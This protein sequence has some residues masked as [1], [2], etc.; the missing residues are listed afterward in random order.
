MVHPTR[1]EPRAARR[2]AFRVDTR[3]LRSLVDTEGPFLTVA[4]P[5]PSRFDDAAHRFEINWRNARSHVGTEWPEQAL[6]RLDGIVADAGHGAGAALF[7]VDSSDGHTLVEFLDEPVREVVASVDPLPRLAPLIESRQRTIAHV[8][9]ETDRAGADLTAFDG[10]EVVTTASIEGETLHIH[11][12]HPGGW[13][14]RRFQQRA[15]NT[16]EHNARTTAEAVAAL[17]SRVDAELIAVAGEVRAR[18]LVL[19]ELPGV[20]NVATVDLQSGSATGIADEVVRR[21]SD[22]VARRVTDLAERVRQGLADGTACNG[23]DATLR[24]L[25]D[26]RV[27][28]L[29]VHDDIDV[30]EPRATHGEIAGIQESRV[31][32]AAIAAALRTDADVVVTPRLAVLD[33]PIGALLRW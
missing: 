31:V 23:I 16:W 10:G 9:V 12:G 17:A 6:E 24:A 26:S 21:L 11:R 3:D 8:V 4:L 7:V 5:T 13:S 19:D 27:Q 15:E 28:T 25:A 22:L 29:L 33:G 1:P 20:T 14:Q 32:D 2:P 18:S 30:E